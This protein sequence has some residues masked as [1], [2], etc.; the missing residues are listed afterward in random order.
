MGLRLLAQAQI[1]VAPLTAYLRALQ[2]RLDGL[3][4]AEAMPGEAPRRGGGLP[5]WAIVLIVVGVVLCA[6]PLCFVIV[7][8]VLTLLGPAIGNVFSNIT[9]SI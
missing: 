9:P 1:A 7:I 3:L 5:V 4:P 8:A 6:I 2:A